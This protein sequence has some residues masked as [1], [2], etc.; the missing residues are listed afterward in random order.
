MR[1]SSKH[2]APGQL[3]ATSQ[4]EQGLI[5]GNIWDEM[6]IPCSPVVPWTILGLL[7]HEIEVQSSPGPQLGN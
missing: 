1:F 7:L 6:G 2:T 3:N 5:M 4:P